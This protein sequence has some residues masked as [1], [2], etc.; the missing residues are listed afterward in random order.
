MD[1]FGTEQ[2]R[3][4]ALLSHSGAGKTSVAE[5]ILLATNTINRLGRIEDGNTVSDYEPEEQRRQTSLQST[6]LTN[7]WKQTKINLLD[8]PGYAEFLGETLSALSVADAAVLVISAPAGIEVG[9]EQMWRRL[10]AKK[11][12][13]VIFINKVDRENADFDAVLDQIRNRFGNQCVALNLPVGAENNFK[14]VYNLMS[15]EA[16]E[17]LQGAV[18]KAKEQITEAVA[19]TDDALT[20]KYLEE[21]RLSS[22]QLTEGLRTAILSGQVVPVLAGAAVTSIGIEELLDVI[23]SYLPSP[24]KAHGVSAQNGDK[25]IQ[26]VADPD[27]PLAAFVFKTSADP[28]VGKLSYFRVYSGTLKSGTEIWNTIKASSERVGQIFVQTGKTQDTVS[29]LAS[30][31]IGSVA[32]LMSVT[33]GDTLGI[34]SG[35]ITLE[36][37]AF[38][39]PTYSVAIAPKSKADNDKM[40]SAL[41]RIVEE[42][43]SLRIG[44]DSATGEFVLSGLGGTHVDVTTERIHRKFGLELE[45]S[46]PRVAYRETI[47]K[48]I[49]AEYRHKKQSGGH[50]QYGHVMMRLEPNPGAGFEFGNEVVGGNVPK[51]YIPSVEKGVVK[52]L[53]EGVLAGFPVVD[54]KAVLYDG[55]SHPVDSSGV[56]FEIAGTMAL[57]KGMSDGSPVLLEPVMKMH[58]TVPS[59][60][61]G[62]II[63]DLNT[64]RAHIG[65]MNPEDGQTTVEA[66]VPQSEVLQ[67]ATNL[68]ALTQGQGYFDM[69]FDHYAE[70]PAHLIP[71]I[72]SEIKGETTHV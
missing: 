59:D 55:S 6:V 65:G 26:L 46:P 44:R 18:E 48:V 39:N 21:G 42:D 51:D 16:S 2:L 31:D 71:R 5:A 15:T 35:P 13:T 23:V 37:I 50:G 38:P 11:I 53:D 7:I 63:G 4:V 45:V 24:D 67:Y 47:S 41:N 22:E 69:E 28:F 8:T 58:I 57:K 49:K 1:K 43:P 29:E 64:R 72:V 9:T 33:T 3:N 14:S 32:K 12:P 10:E 40:S 34:K 70:V 68:R 27:G 61:T 52:A 19:E 20:E 62:E 36:G 25:A 60:Y 30:G 17:G 66:Q 56:S 54:V